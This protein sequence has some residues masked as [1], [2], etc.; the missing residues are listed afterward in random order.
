MQMGDKYDR[1]NAYIGWDVGGWHCEKNAKSRDALVI[2]DGDRGLV[3]NPWRGNLRDLIL[4]SETTGAFI[5]GLFACCSSAPPPKGDRIL[6]A[7]DIPLAFPE[8][9]EALLRSGEVLSEMGGSQDNPYIFRQ[10]ERFL[11]EKGWRPLS[12][13]K[14]MIGSQATKGMHVLSRFAPHVDRTGVWTDRKG[15]EAF[16]SYPS[17]GRRH[18]RIRTLRRSISE[19]PH[20]DCEDA[21]ICALTACLFATEP[22]LLYQPPPKTPPSEGWI[23]VPGG[24]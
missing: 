3:G 5:A 6:M 24:S 12:P 7:I 15:F 2:L 19:M 13:L 18:P 8:A 1:V 9:F 4:E 17:V 21:L 22:D 20:Q 16:E 11:A 23:W 10:T 14:D